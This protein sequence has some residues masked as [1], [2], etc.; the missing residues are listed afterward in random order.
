M[1]KTLSL[2]IMEDKPG[3]L[4]TYV[5]DAGKISRTQ[6]QKLI[7][8][9]MVSL[10]EETHTKTGTRLNKGDIIFVRIPVEKKEP[11]LPAQDIPMDVV[12]ED[13]H[14]IAV[15]KVRGMV[16]HPA[17]GHHDGTLVN[18]LLYHAEQIENVGQE[19]RPGVVHRL[20]KN[21]SGL[22]I[23]AKT[24]KAH[25]E[26]SNM[27]AARK[28]KKEY[29]AIVHGKVK[30]R[31]GKINLPIGRDPN[32]RKKMA[33]T[34]GGKSSVTR[35]KCKKIFK[36]WTM[37]SVFPETG[38]T[39]QIRVHFKYMGNPL[40]SDPEYAVG[41][42]NPTDMEGQALHCHRLEFKHPITKDPMSLEA[43]LPEDMERLIEELEALSGL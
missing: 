7:K 2:Y 36:D 41:Y 39:H 43:P 20:D 19:G 8:D 37:L 11:D 42:E 5:S 27:F 16:V 25:L 4:D 18:A 33:V 24:N 21:T 22:I 12:Y 28:I 29:I 32:D 1:E 30:G 10:N 23:A 9:G 17:A 40:I 35:W 34:P 31:E 38:R 14:I 3:R 15:N 26:L 6:A 13:E